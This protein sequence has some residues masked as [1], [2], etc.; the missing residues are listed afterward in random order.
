MRRTLKVKD[1]SDSTGTCSV[2][3]RTERA[4]FDWRFLLSCPMRPPFAMEPEVML[5]AELGLIIDGPSST[6]C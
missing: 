6:R 4:R 2:R 5:L 1:I 3:V